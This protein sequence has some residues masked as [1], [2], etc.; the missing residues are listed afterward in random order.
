VP[1]QDGSIVVVARPQ[2][3]IGSWI[4]PNRAIAKLAS[5]TAMTA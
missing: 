4:W 5:A 3:F 2:R 1:Y